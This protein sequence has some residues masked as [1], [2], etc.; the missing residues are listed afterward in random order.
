MCKPPPLDRLTRLVGLNDG[1]KLEVSKKNYDII[2]KTRRTN[3]KATAKD[4]A[5]EKSVLL[6]IIPK[7]IRRHNTIV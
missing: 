5:Y 4:L 7:V 3:P 2:E 6:K 1:H